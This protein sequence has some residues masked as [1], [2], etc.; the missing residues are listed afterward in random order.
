MKI[1]KT[2]YKGGKLLHNTD[3]PADRSHEVI[4]QWMDAIKDKSL[5]DTLSAVDKRLF[6]ESPAFETDGKK[7][8]AKY[9]RTRTLKRRLEALMIRAESVRNFRASMKAKSAGLM[10]AAPLCIWGSWPWG[11]HDWSVL[12]MQDLGNIKPLPDYLDALKPQNR[13]VKARIAK[14]LALDLAR[15]HDEKIYVHDPAKNVLVVE[16]G[17]DFKMAFIDFDTVRWY[18]PVNKVQV[19]RVL[20]HCI[21]PPSDLEMF[22]RDEIGIYVREYL[23]ARGLAAWFDEVFPLV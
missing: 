11:M 16:E 2:K 20:R 23:K 17:G 15:L 1:L 8:R 7:Y 19:A 10:T 21:R 12:F 6:I 22:S 3:Y 13:D 18:L 4:D 14:T 5:A 9:Y